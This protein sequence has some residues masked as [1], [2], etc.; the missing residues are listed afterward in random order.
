MRIPPP[1][2]WKHL[3][4]AGRFSMIRTAR[5]IF[6]AGAQPWLKLSDRRCLLLCALL[7]TA[8]VLA[9]IPVLEMGINDDWSY[10]WTARAFASTGQLAYNRWV[11]AMVGV[12]AIWA[13]LLIKAFGFSFTL[14]RLSTLPFAA[15]C[16]VLLY[17]LCRNAGLNKR[18]AVFGTLAVTL[19]P[20][21]IPLAASF[22]TDVPGLFFWLASLHCALRALRAGS[23]YRVCTWLAATATLGVAGGTVRQVVWIVPLVTIPFVAWVRR[24]ERPALATAAVLWVASALAIALCLRWFSAQTHGA[25]SPG[26]SWPLP[27][28]VEYLVES[29]FQ[30]A[31]GCLVLMLPVLAIHVTRP[32]RR[33]LAGLLFSALVLGVELWVF[34]DSLLLGNIVE[35]TGILGP[36]V[37][38]MGRK[39]EMLAPPTLVLLGLAVFVSAGFTCAALFTGWPRG[40]RPLGQFA[41]VFGPPSALYTAAIL[42]RAVKDWLLFDRYLIVLFPVLVIPVLWRSQED[43]RKTPPKIGWAILALF[44]LYGVATTHDYLAAGRAR[45]EAAS[46]LTTAGI[47]RTRITAGLEY[48][49]WTQI[50][51]TGIP[52][53][54]EDAGSRPAEP[55]YWF[56]QYTPSVDPVYFVAYSRL[57]GLRD[58]PFPPVRYTAWLPPFHR[59]AFTQVR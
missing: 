16:A 13:G 21:F 56:W 9:S 25:T 8:C 26:E 30:V 20:V 34:R 58:A 10:A 45:L 42:Y 41:F 22:M 15:G 6:G 49:G 24:R 27:L 23:A 28:F 11:G 51:H 2:T 1:R 32:P 29:A 48:D 57:P 39:S 43:G 38:A 53:A 40:V 55:S 35:P 14:V 5:R 31:V 50:E 12:Q 52:A 36:G 44:A 54:E 18:F 7:V 4:N 46:A 19:S 37:E 47:P 3:T 33:W 17:R 59:Q